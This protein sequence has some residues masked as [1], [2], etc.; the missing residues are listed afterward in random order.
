MMLVLSLLACQHFGKMNFGKD[1]PTDLTGN[2][3][4][5]TIHPYCLDDS[6]IVMQT[7]QEGDYQRYYSQGFIKYATVV[8]PNGGVIPIFAQDEVSDEQLIR[9]RSLLMFFLTDVPGSQWGADKSSV[10][11][12]MVENSA[13][14][15][16]PNGEH[17]EGNEPNLQS[18]PLY[19]AETP[20]EGSVWFMENDFEHRDAAFE[21]IFHLVHD[22][23]IGTYLP[24][25][26]PDYQVDLDAEARA[27]ISDGRWGIEVEP[28][29]QDWLDELE[30]E[31][32]LAQ[33]YIAS[34]IDSYYGLWGPWTEA[35][36][37]MWGI[38]IAK[39]RA[40]ISEKDSQG[41]LLLEQFLSE[42][43]T[44]E[45]RLSSELSEDFTLTFD[46]NQPYT[47]K[48]QYFVN[49]TLTGSRSTNLTGNGLDNSLR[50]NSGDNTIDGSVGDD[51][52][53]LCNNRAE[54]TITQQEELILI[55]GPDGDD[56]L[57]QIEWFHFADGRL[58]IEDLE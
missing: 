23:G 6:G 28:G 21:E 7:P 25:A 14:L 4:P 9:A 24:G 29:V 16:M 39:D 13:S 56:V 36:G 42:Y 12:K 49:V 57:Q 35:Q 2:I 3:D 30:R 58:A 44:T 8:A 38:Y 15:M 37:G 46:A 41:Q 54:Y 20:V 22:T 48:S 5:T 55:S 50:G 45:V 33:E 32:S 43:Y 34:V 51:V 31:D 47:H 52:F 40:E 11:N 17:E 1:D 26:L 27:A 18:Q 10:A 19:S 53:I